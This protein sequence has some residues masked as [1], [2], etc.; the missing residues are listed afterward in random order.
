MG[1][2]AEGCCA[3]TF[4]LGRRAELRVLTTPLSLWAGRRSTGAKLHGL[5]WD[6]RLRAPRS[7]GREAASALHSAQGSRGRLSPACYRY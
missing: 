1:L 4:E 3:Q 2:E 6:G 7:P 5:R